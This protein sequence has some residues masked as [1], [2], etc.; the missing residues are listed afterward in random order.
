M[1]I[2]ILT[3]CHQQ[4]VAVYAC[5]ADAIAKR[6]AFNADPYLDTETPDTDAP[7]VIETWTVTEHSQVLETRADCVNDVVKVLAPNALLPVALTADEQLNTEERTLD[8]STRTIN[9]TTNMAK[10][11]A[12]YCG[13][14][15]QQP[16]PGDEVLCCTRCNHCIMVAMSSYERAW[17]NREWA[18]GQLKPHILERL[19]KA[20]GNRM[21]LKS[22]VRGAHRAAVALDAID[23]AIA[24]GKRAD[25]DVTLAD[26]VYGA[27]VSLMNEKRVEHAYRNLHEKPSERTYKLVNSLI[28]HKE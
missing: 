16:A 28:S 26:I 22:L 6:D 15:G 21:S 8:M 13:R 9:V 23:A 12:V 7:Y 3:N 20:S 10:S 5:E 11:L 2:T 14:C 18:I 4:T 27:V 19:G 1:T 25:F 17:R 24:A